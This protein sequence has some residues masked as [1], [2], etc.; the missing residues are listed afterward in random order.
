M[1]KAALQSKMAFTDHTYG[2]ADEDVL[3]LKWSAA[4]LLTLAAASWAAIWF[5]VS[6]VL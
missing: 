3:P 5:V 1:T 4:L 6:L 2:P